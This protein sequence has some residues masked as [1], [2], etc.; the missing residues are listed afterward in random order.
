MTNVQKRSIHSAV[1]YAPIH[2]PNA[3]RG[4]P[5]IPVAYLQWGKINSESVI[6][7]TTLPFADTFARLMCITHWK[8]RRNIPYQT[9]DFGSVAAI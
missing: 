4:K 3:E 5:T 9:S 6:F 1:R 8:I 7:L 2:S